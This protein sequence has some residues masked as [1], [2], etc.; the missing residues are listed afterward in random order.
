[1]K[2]TIWFI[3][4]SLF[5]LSGTAQVG[6]GAQDKDNPFP[7]VLPNLPEL[8]ATDKEEKQEGEKDGP[9]VIDLTRPTA[10][11]PNQGQDK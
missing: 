6:W 2:K 8:P 1:M 5:V 3:L 7:P 11:T 9:I 10:D 4:L